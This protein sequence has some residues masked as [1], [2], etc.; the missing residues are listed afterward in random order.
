MEGNRYG[1]DDVIALLRDRGIGFEETRHGPVYTVDEMLAL[2][3]PHPESIAK[4]LFLRDDKKRS[5]YLVVCREDRRVDLKALR[6]VIGSRPL[7]MASEDDLMSI[8]GLTRGSVTPFGL[9]NDHDGRVD[10]VVDSYFR[11]SIMGVHP[12][13]NT[14]TLWI[15]TD[16]LIS[17]VGD[18]CRSWAFHDLP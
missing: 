5:Y 6:A 1:M 7:S 10:L 15:R 9:L 8:L 3:M 2:D 18:R 14:C 17:I 11:D 12:N 4:N 16:D 13:D